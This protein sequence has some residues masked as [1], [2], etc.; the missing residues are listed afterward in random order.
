[1]MQRLVP[2]AV[3]C[4]GAALWAQP[5]SL[6]YEAETCVVTPDAIVKDAFPPDKWTLWTTDVDADKKWSGGAVVKSPNVQ[7][8][9][10]TPEEGAPPIQLTL[11][12]IP[13]GHYD[14][15]VKRAR[16][17]AVSLDGL[18]W[19]R[20]QGDLIARGIAVESGTFTF[21]VDDRF[22]E[23]DPKSRGS[24]YLDWIE[25]ESMAAYV[26]G[27]WNGGFEVLRDGGP[28]GW[29]LP[30]ASDTM[31]AAI[32][33]NDAHSGKNALRISSTVDVRTRWDCNCGKRTPV[34][35]GTPMRVSA[36]V[37]GT[38]NSGCIRVDGLQDGKRIQSFL[39]RA[40]LENSGDWSCLS[41]YFIVPEEA[42]ELSYSVH[43]YGPAEILID[44]LS[45]EPAALP[46]VEGRKVTGWAKTRIAENLDRGVIALRTPQ[47]AYV[48]WRLL[49]SDPANVAFNV[50]R[51]VDGKSEEK[52]NPEPI[53]QTCDFGDSGVP[54]T[55]IVSYRVVPLRRVKPAGETVLA[56]ATEDTPHVTIKLREPELQA[57]RVAVGDLDGDGACDFVIKHPNV[58]K[59]PFHTFW[60][61][62][63]TTYKLDAYTSRGEFLWRRDLGWAIEA[64]TWY[65]P[66]VVCDVTG[67]GR[68]EVIA[69]TGEGDPRDKEGKVA[70]GP[71]WLTVMDGLTGEDICRTPWPS[72]SGFSSYN[73]A[74]RNQLAIA[75]LDGKTPCV[76]ALRGT[77][78]RMKVEAHMIRNGC[79]E[80]LWSYDNV[81]C[82]ATYWGQG[83]HTTRAVD[84][85]GDGRDEV[86][87]GSVCLDDDGTPL[88]TT[89]R[90]H[91]D[92]L[93][94][95][96]ILPSH[97]GMEAFYCMETAQKVDGGLS[98][99][100]A[101]TGEFIWKLQ[102][103]TRHVHSSGMCADM[104]P[105]VR[106]RECYGSDTDEDKRA[107]RAWFMSAD[108][109]ELQT[110]LIYGYTEP[111][112]FWDAD[113][114]RE[115]FSG[116]IKDHGGGPLDARIGKGVIADILGD[117]R[118]EV[119]VSAPG[120]LRIYS[121]TIPAMD[122]R[123]CLL[124]DPVYRA[125]VCMSS[126]GYGTCPTP[127]EPF[128]ESA[129]NL[130]LTFV[131]G[132]DGTVCRIVVSA[133]PPVPADPGKN[134]GFLQAVRKIFAES[135][136]EKDGS[137]GIHGVLYLTAAP[138]LKL[139]QSEFAVDVAPGE[140]AEY[141]D[142]VT[143]AEPG[144]SL[145][146]Y[147]HAELETG[148]R[149]LRGQVWAKTT[150][151]P[152]TKGALVEAENYSGEQ[153]G[154]VHVRTDK[155]NVRGKCISHWDRKGHALEWQIDVPEKGRYEFLVRYCA[156][157]EGKRLL[158]LNGEEIRELTFPVSGGYGS[159]PEDWDEITFQKAP[160]TWF[161]LEKGT[162][163]I[164]LEN[165]SDTGMN[166]D[167][168]GFVRR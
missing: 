102:G 41:G 54:E 58:G 68:A 85:D 73:F 118:E 152:V 80:K 161:Q 28:N 140:F 26:N 59:D 138:G 6:R 107:N 19:E 135:T 4:L 39:G 143:G 100:D 12:D 123:V 168:L 33:T 108:G 148:R 77:Y 114:Q 132:D 131:A 128:A 51:R 34:A 147:I 79:F 164:R 46:K 122:R 160:R 142:P 117:W 22:A 37:K 49:A 137:E 2:I 60:V 70:S 105:T 64:G 53:V 127:R 71:E 38:I 10:A 30:K 75:Y 167:Y 150:G 97:P 112:I 78:G 110:G 109:R 25:L 151:K 89:G 139:E 40:I 72:R 14:I 104:D 98:L 50:F 154:E 146:G 45:I 158:A 129:P 99:V 88:W 18:H 144:G 29:S 87:L 106:G 3:S 116:I 113:L 95:A 61:P 91:P 13:S 9:R 16:A 52:L 149:V 27:V 159:Q 162:Y 5:D 134:R 101:A 63:D 83:S 36:W 11:K 166:L 165:T 125:C 20:L 82:P 21:W 120:E 115:I 32:T 42:N 31:S 141:T 124:Q 86:V 15:R 1:M 23:E 76:L 90:G 119:I 24:S 94:V 69:K 103:P 157:A 84:V 17:L 74:S 44:D 163:T 81:N 155:A 35:P 126:M 156:P 8:D 92:A 43:A 7:A 145:D 55:G 48:S 153:G 56:P 93:H 111:T 67:N 130:N 136:A 96:D 47:G 65:S 66:F 121:T 62:S 57:N 133:P